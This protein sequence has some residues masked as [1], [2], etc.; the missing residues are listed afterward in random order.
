MEHKRAVGSTLLLLTLDDPVALD[1]PARHP[2]ARAV[3]GSK[4]G[5][6]HGLTTEASLRLQN[7]TIWDDPSNGEPAEICPGKVHIG[8]LEEH[9]QY[10]VDPAHFGLKLSRSHSEAVRPFEGVS[11]AS[12]ALGDGAKLPQLPRAPGGEP[13][14]KLEHLV[15][16]LD[17]RWGQDVL[18]AEH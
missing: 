11:K 16:C 14:T 5:E 4:L 9:E 15:D 3:L 7:V 10:D 18:G 1:R 17:T 12:S 6:R 13:V 8:V 2:G